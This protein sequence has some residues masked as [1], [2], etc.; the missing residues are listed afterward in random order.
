MKSEA[1]IA[2]L[3]AMPWILGFLTFLLYPV[4]A[5]FFYSFT[6]FSVLRPPRFIGLENYKEMVQDEVFW[7]TIRNTFTY[8]V[9]AVPL[10][11][12]VAI[13]LAMLLNTKVKGLAFYRT[14][15]Y[16]PSLVPMVALGILWLWIFNGEHGL[17]DG[18]HGPWMG[19]PCAVAVAAGGMSE[20]AH[21]DV[22]DDH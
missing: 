18:V 15:F 12:T 10:S 6:D 1:R 17:L 2:Y 21:L 22:A 8:V 9:A 16:V 3:F 14:L 11:A 19:M 13:I 5:S 20:D 4:M 7:M